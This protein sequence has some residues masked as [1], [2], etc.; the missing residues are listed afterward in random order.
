[1]Q[2][3]RSSPRF[4]SA[5]VHESF[6]AAT[7]SASV[8]GCF[9]HSIKDIGERLGGTECTHGKSGISLN[10][11]MRA[12]KHPLIRQLPEERTAVNNQ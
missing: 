5:L 2:L 1:M 6:L 8:I 12:R 11:N 7:S 10:E 9:W 3:A 4:G